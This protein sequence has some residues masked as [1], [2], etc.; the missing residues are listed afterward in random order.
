[1][2]PEGGSDDSDHD[3]NGTD[4]RMVME[5]EPLCI[6]D[7]N[8]RHIMLEFLDLESCSE[9]GD[10]NDDDYWN[11]LDIVQLSIACWEITAMIMQMAMLV[12]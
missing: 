2:L 9:L 8:I 7:I 1:M 12:T 11:V 6:Q 4:G 5:F 3:Y 10:V